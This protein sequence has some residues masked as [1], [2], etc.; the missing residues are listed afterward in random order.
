VLGRP[1]DTYD[2]LATQAPH[3]SA[4][5]P[6]A[7]TRALAQGGIEASRSPTGMSPPISAAGRGLGR[8]GAAGSR[9]GHGYLGQWLE[10]QHQSRCLRG[11]GTPAQRL[12]RSPGRPGQR[13]RRFL[14]TR[15]VDGAGRGGLRTVPRMPPRIILRL[16]VSSGVDPWPPV[17]TPSARPRLPRTP[18]SPISPLMGAGERP[19]LQP[20]SS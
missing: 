8:V 10:P 16:E 14:R 9:L 2:G 15:A 19:R 12:A 7:K 5:G 20:R 17:G 11:R 6:R 1:G 18:T 3:R 4:E 13:A